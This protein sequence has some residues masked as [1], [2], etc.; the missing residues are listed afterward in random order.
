MSS[1][2]RCE[3]RLYSNDFD[4][5]SAITRS[6]PIIINGAYMELSDFLLIASYPV[7]TQAWARSKEFS[8][9]FT[10]IYI[11]AG[12]P[13]RRSIMNCAIDRLRHRL[14]DGN[15]FAARAN[16]SCTSLMSSM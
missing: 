14:F 13:R 16:E 12:I 7:R 11:T 6:W 1:L 8:E 15:R 9:D 4:A 5:D 2:G 10:P 3:S